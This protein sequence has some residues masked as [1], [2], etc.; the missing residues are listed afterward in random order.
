MET[1]NPCCQLIIWFESEWA[2]KCDIYIGFLSA[3]HLQCRMEA[4]M[5]MVLM[6]ASWYETLLSRKDSYH[7]GHANRIIY[8]MVLVSRQDRFEMLSFILLSRHKRYLWIS[9]Q[10]TYLELLSRQESCLLIWNC[11]EDRWA[12]WRCWGIKTHL[13]I[14]HSSY[15]HASVSDLYI[16]RICLPIWLQQNRQRN[17]GNI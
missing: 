14:V 10:V 12:A 11:A 15:S 17:P 1:I 9:R 7:D 8:C 6:K 2:F 5:L 13:A 4:H 16:P 3:L